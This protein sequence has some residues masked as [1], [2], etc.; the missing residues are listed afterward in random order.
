MPRAGAEVLPQVGALVESPAAYPRLSGRANLRVHDALG[1][2][3]RSG[4]A[5]RVDDVLAGASLGVD[6]AAT[7]MDPISALLANGLGWAIEYFDPLREMLDELT[8]KP[9][10]V[11]SHAQTWANMAGEFA[12]IAD[13]LERPAPG[14][15]GQFAWGDRDRIEAALEEAGFVE[16]LEI[17]RVAFTHTYPDGPA[18]YYTVLAPA[19][20]R[21]EI[22]QWDE[23]K[24]AASEAI[25]AAGGT[26]THHHAVGRDHR[27]WYDRQRPDQRREERGLTG[28]TG[29]G[30]GDNAAQ[31]C[32]ET[33]QCRGPATGIANLE[34]CD[35]DRGP[36]GFSQVSPGCY[37]EMFAHSVQSREAIL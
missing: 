7:V 37:L 27:P 26:I 29:P 35:A 23:V 34:P 24:A 22:E 13:E 4:R 14:D 2:G 36:V 19:R 28:S 30:H 17:E 16:D 6:V 25:L 10:V 18:P 15:P 33:S 5:G 32:V 3:R 11:Q 21:S 12:S 20:R 31:L 8:G 9:D 1:R